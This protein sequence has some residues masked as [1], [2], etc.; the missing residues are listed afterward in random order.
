MILM[1]MSRNKNRR[2]IIY[3]GVLRNKTEQKR[4]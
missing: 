4:R 3:D 2:E 1:M